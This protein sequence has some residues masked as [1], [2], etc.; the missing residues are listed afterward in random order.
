MIKRLFSLVVVSLMTVAMGCGSD[1]E[2]VRL[3][4]S[5]EWTERSDGLP[6]FQDHYGFEFPEL[7]IVDLGLSYQSVGTELAEVGVGDATEGRIAQY[8][9][10]I[11]ED[12]QQFFPA[13]NPAPLVR[14]EILE[15]YP[16]LQETLRE[17]SSRLDLDT[18]TQLNKR[19]SVEQVMPQKVAAEF[20]ADEGLAG[21]ATASDTSGEKT[22]PIVV[23]SKTFPEALIL[24]YLTK[25]LLEERGY[26]VVDQIGLGEVAVISPALFSGQVDLY[27]EYTGTGLMNVMGYDGVISDPQKCY[28]MVSDWYRENHDVIWL[29]YA[30]ANNTFVLFTSREMHNRHGWETITDLAEYLNNK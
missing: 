15:T 13:Y 5:A 16:E 23:A 30:P 18:L 17:L 4:T 11:L 27:W 7:V 24:G 1:G 28:D 19:V 6:G 2:R 8:D 12:D 20:L 25:H 21:Q 3:A 26:P 22:E 29:D 10:V 9:L 14:R